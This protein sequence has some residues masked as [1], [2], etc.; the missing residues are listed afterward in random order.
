[1]LLCAGLW[2]ESFSMLF[3]P[4]G[5]WLTAQ[6]APSTIRATVMGWML[7]MLILDLARAMQGDKRCPCPLSWGTPEPPSPVVAGQWCQLW[8]P[9]SNQTGRREGAGPVLPRGRR[10]LAGWALQR[11]RTA[12]EWADPML[13]PVTF[14][15]T[16]PE[17]EVSK[18]LCCRAGEEL[19]EEISQFCLLFCSHVREPHFWVCR[20]EGFWLGSSVNRDPK[21]SF[22][23]GH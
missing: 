19:A 2:T 11:G 4:H 21:Q 16:L 5:P 23:L 20:V 10:G 15:V 9:P 3:P 14:P 18:L 7:L 13:I 17:P 8:M 1:M 12:Q 22:F 6:T